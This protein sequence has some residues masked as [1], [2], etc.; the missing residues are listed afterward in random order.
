MKKQADV[1]EAFARSVVDG[2]T[3]CAASAVLACDRHLRDLARVGWRWRYD[4][5]RADRIMAFARELTLSGGQWEG[6]PWEPLPWQ[7]FL[8]RSVFGWCDADGYRRFRKVYIEAPKGTGK[9]MLSAAVGLYLLHL[10]GERRPEI[11]CLAETGDQ[12]QIVFDCARQIMDRSEDL[13][14]WGYIYGGDVVPNRIMSHDGGFIRR[15]DRAQG[16]RGRSGF[17]PSGILVDELHEVRDTGLITLYE[18]GTKSRRNPLT[19]TTTNTGAGAAQGT[20]CWVEHAH[21]LRVVRGEVDDERYLGLVYE[22]DRDLD[23]VILGREDLWPAFNP[24]LPATPGYEYLRD[25][26]RMAAQ[27]PSRRS[28]VLRL[29]FGRWSDAADP[30]L[31]VEGWKA[32]QVAPDALPP[33]AGPVVAALDLST[34]TDLTG[35]AV[36]WEVGDGTIALMATGWTPEEGLEQRAQLDSADYERWVKD[37]HLVATPGRIVDYSIV[38]EWVMDLARGEQGLRCV[39]SDSHGRTHFR[40]ALEKFGVEVAGSFGEAGGEEIVMVYH[41]QGWA[42][43]LKKQEEAR[44]DGNLYPAMPTSIADFEELVAKEQLIVARNPALTSSVLNAVTIKDN[45]ANRKFAK[46][47]SYSRIDLCI[48]A[49]C[50]VGILMQLRHEDSMGDIEEWLVA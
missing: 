5:Q 1:A 32:V 48:A 44:G 11:Y 38:A 43:H 50:A 20:P 41:P 28:E 8:L 6:L 33:P 40:E 46:T 13:S 36:C 3:P 4:V 42:E 27:S 14:A 31:H 25:Q 45:H 35:G 2:E 19:F 21:A 47:K 16:G 17:V 24:S 39:G 26:V 12:A 18:A 49:V 7:E 30:W 23:D 22:L 15:V 9:V 10:D 37:G 34:R 29:N